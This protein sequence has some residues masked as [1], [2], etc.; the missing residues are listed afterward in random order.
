[1]RVYQFREFGKDFYYLVGTFTASSDN[2]NIRFCLLGNSML[3]YRLS[4]TERTGDKSCPSLYNGVYR[5][6]NTYTGFQ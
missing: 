5:I 2:N 1:M 4:C 3:K 6:N